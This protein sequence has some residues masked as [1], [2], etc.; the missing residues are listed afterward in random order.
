MIRKDLSPAKG[1]SREAVSF[2]LATEADP[3]FR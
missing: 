3:Y 1:L 2:S